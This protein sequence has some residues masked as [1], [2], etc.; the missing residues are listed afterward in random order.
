MTGACS[1]LTGNRKV[2]KSAAGKPEWK[3]PFR[4]CRQ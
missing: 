1:I 3:R 2:S 4:R